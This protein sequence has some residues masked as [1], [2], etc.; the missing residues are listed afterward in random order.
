MSFFSSKSVVNLVRGK[1]NTNLLL[2]YKWLALPVKWN[3]DICKVNHIIFGTFE[4]Y[5]E[6]GSYKNGKKSKLTPPNITAWLGFIKI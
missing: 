2:K 6:K 1:F 4:P 3:W 5:F